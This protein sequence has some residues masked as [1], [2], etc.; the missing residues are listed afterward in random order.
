MPSEA[1]VVLVHGLWMTGVDM[2]LLARRLRRCGFDARIFRY[3]SLRGSLGHNAGLLG[4]YLERIPAD[5]IHLVGHSLGG[6]VIRRLVHDRPDLCRGRIVTLGTPH[7]GSRCAGSFCRN[8]IGRLLL[9]RSLSPLLGELPIWGGQ[10]AMGS[11]A[12][13][14]GVGFGRL[15]ARLPLPNDGTVA[16]CETRIPGLADVTTVHTTHS[17]LLFSPE[18]ARQTCAF[19]RDGAFLHAP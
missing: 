2:L 19:L 18:A 5:T 1:T 16:L 17:G 4:R 9:G 7:S 6:L 11:I 3:P 14:L 10:W 15:I 13:T 8:P 12:G